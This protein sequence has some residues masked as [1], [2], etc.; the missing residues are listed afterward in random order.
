MQAISSSHDQSIHKVSKGQLIFLLPFILFFI[1]LFIKIMN[2]GFYMYLVHEDSILEYTQVVFYMTACL[3]A[4]LVAYMYWEKKHNVPAVLYFVLALGLLFVSIEEISWGQRI[5][6]IE[7]PDYFA[8]HNVQRETTLHN[9]DVVQPLLRHIYILTGF[10]GAFSLPIFSFLFSLRTLKKHHA[11]KTITPEWY[12][13]SYFFIGFFIYTLFHYV[14]PAA[15][16]FGISALDIG[17]FFSWRDEE[18]AELF[19]SLGFAIF[20]LSKYVNLRKTNTIT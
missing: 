9:L 3:F 8:S 18:V 17:P 14:R 11:L 2:V 7:N 4:G 19:L 6:N 10:Y 20:A 16:Y 1:F 15:G 13:C 5:L 12:V